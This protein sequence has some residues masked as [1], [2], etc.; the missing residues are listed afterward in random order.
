MNQ[1]DLFKISIVTPSFNQGKFIEDT[2]KSVL[3]QKY[4]NFEHIIIDGGSTDGTVDILKKYPHLKWVSEPDKGQSDALN[5]GFKMAKGEW[6]LWL[7]SD[8]MLFENTIHNYIEVINK[9]R[10]INLLYGHTV[11]IDSKKDI[12]KKVYQLNYR[13]FMTYYDTYIPPTSGTLFRTNLL[14]KQPLDINYHIVMDL[15]W[16]F[17]FG[18]NINAKVIDD[19]SV[20]FRISN[21]NK[22][23]KH[24]NTGIRNLQHD[25]ERTMIFNKYVYK[26]YDTKLKMVIYSFNHFLIYI[27]YYLMKLR[28]LYK[29]IRDRI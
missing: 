28:Y 23:S 11:F 4:E 25:K 26:K 14:K 17:E 2:I 6:I 16:F 7:N 27:Y 20:S 13:Y 19:Y 9:N 18:Q 5:K 3:N 10:H 29:Y 15:K 1:K 21:E 22:T 24:F 12:L 8:D